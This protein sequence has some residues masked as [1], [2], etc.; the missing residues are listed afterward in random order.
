M[1]TT[2]SSNMIN[3]YSTNPE[4]I[5]DI[6]NCPN[7]LVTR[8]LIR[9]HCFVTAEKDKTMQYVEKCKSTSIQDFKWKK[10]TPVH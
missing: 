7:G 5:S 1:E 3:S 9:L 8:K 2:S 6:T 4:S 10:Q